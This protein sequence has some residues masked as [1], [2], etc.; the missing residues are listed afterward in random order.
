M[1]ANDF[2]A[3]LLNH[4]N[5][6]PLTITL[7]SYNQQIQDVRD[8]EQLFTFGTAGGNSH[9]T[10]QEVARFIDGFK[11]ALFGYLNGSG[12]VPGTQGK[13]VTVEEFNLRA[14]DSL[15]R[16]KVMLRQLTDSWLLP[17]EDKLGYKI[18]VGSAPRLWHRISY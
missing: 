8:L 13:S 4:T 1:Q 12:H 7:S 17:M 15:F 3:Q 16:A 10:R 14:S 5:L 2:R 11:N 6:S 9:H 18:L